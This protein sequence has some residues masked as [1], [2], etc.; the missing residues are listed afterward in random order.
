[1]VP[2]LCCC[3]KPSVLSES[4]HFSHLR[5]CCI[6]LR[7]NLLDL[8][9]WKKYVRLHAAMNITAFYK[10]SNNFFE[11]VLSNLLGWKIAEVSMWKQKQC[12]QR[13]VVWCLTW[14][15]A[16]LNSYLSQTEK[17][18]ATDCTLHHKGDFLF[19]FVKSVDWFLNH[20]K[21]GNWLC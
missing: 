19:F 5:G 8:R 9:Q 16:F 18:F 7:P 11:I 20:Y 4:K 3:G 10:K 15:I 14:N 2:L 6:I 21:Y 13:N 17:E 12:F 1:M